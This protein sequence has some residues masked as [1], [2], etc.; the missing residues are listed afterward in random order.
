MILYAA[1]TREGGAA[2]DCRVRNLSS[3]GAC[4]D[5]AAAL[6]PGQRATVQMGALRPM[7]ADVMWVERGFA[8]LRFDGAVDLAAARR[9][10]SKTVVAAQAG[11]IGNLGDAYR[12][13]A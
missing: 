12:R 10:R 6:R 4:I 11:W 9:P 2:V 8:G 13:S 7:G 1:V 5:D 3:T